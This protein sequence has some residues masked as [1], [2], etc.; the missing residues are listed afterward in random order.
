[1]STITKRR[2]PLISMN[3]MY[4]LIN[5]RDYDHKQIL[6]LNNY[7]FGEKLYTN[8][9]E[10]NNFYRFQRPILSVNALVQYEYYRASSAK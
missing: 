3:T 1:M 9:V 7:A 5:L 4:S 8:M 10:I 2:S 6:A